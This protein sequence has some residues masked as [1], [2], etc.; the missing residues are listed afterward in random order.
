M[1]PFVT[2]AT[3]TRTI[4]A[5]ASFESDAKSLPIF[6]YLY[7]SELDQNVLHNLSVTDLNG[8]DEDRTCLQLLDGKIIKQSLLKSQDNAPV[9]GA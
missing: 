4:P 5:V 2:V 3:P 9:P 8:Q 6:L 7:S 1:G